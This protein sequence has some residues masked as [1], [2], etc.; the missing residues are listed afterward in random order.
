[1]NVPRLCDELHPRKHRILRHGGE[2]RRVAAEG[3]VLITRDG[4]GEVKTEAIDVHLRDPI[5]Q[6]IEDEAQTGR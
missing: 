3:I 2:K 1:M 6:R 5:T 4:H